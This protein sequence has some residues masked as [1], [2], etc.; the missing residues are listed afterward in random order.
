MDLQSV[1]AIIGTVLLAAW[2]RSERNKHRKPPTGQSKDP[3]EQRPP[4]TEPP[5]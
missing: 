2:M 3:Q 5:S 4:D 1:V